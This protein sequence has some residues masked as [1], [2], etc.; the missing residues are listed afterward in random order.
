MLLLFDD[1]K[2]KMIRKPGK[3]QKENPVGGAPEKVKD[4]KE[5]QE[6]GPEK[7]RR[8]PSVFEFG[9]EVTLVIALVNL[10]HRWTLNNVCKYVSKF[11]L[12]KSHI[13]ELTH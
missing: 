1:N 12:N 4:E 10:T 11:L 9:G 6:K 8:E 13:S 5:I 3:K 2:I 7:V